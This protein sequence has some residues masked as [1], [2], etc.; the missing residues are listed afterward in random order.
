MSFLGAAVWGFSS[1]LKS[2]AGSAVRGEGG[3]NAASNIEFRFCN[4]VCSF[5]E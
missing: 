4:L 1:D 5:D 2:A 3:E